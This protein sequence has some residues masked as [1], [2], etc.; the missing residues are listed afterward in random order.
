MTPA[1]DGQW[2]V[3]IEEKLSD[4]GYGAS[5]KLTEPAD[6]GGASAELEAVIT[7]RRP[8]LVTIPQGARVVEFGP[9]QFGVVSDHRVRGPELTRIS[10][11]RVRT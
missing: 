9:G 2:V 10:L 1:P 6:H 5:I 4:H 8:D 7:G 11:T 3:L